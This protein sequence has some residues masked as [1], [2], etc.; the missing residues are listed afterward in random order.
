MINVFLDDRRP[1]PPGFVL[2]RTAEECMLLLEECD[3]NILSL[4]HDLGPGEPTGYDVAAFIVRSGKYPREIYLHT[5]SDWG[6]SRMFQILYSN[7]PEGV[8]VHMYGMPEEVLRREAA[9]RRRDGRVGGPQDGGRGNGRTRDG[10]P[11]AP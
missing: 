4:D 5:S 3:V 6:R 10:E 2:A 9:A 1:C 11:E 8:M 7:R